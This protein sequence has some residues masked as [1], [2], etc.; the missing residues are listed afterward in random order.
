MAEKSS[1]NMSMVKLEKL[2]IEEIDVQDE[3][4]D[5]FQKLSSCMEKSQRQVS[6]SIQAHVQGMN[7]NINDLAEEVS[8][9]EAELSIVTKERDDLLST[10][11]KLSGEIRQWSAR[12]PAKESLQQTDISCYDD[13]YSLS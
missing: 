7:K 11:N 8:N 4:R 5:V 1:A 13:K 2:G 10:I 6:L 9:L 12:S 3:V